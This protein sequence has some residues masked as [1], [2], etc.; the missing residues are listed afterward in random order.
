MSHFN[1]DKRHFIWNSLGTI[2][3]S[4]VSIM[5]LLFTARWLSGKETDIFSIA[6]ALAQQFY[7]LGYFYVRNYQATDVD[8][9]YTFVDYWK[10][11]LVTVFLMLATAAIYIWFSG[12]DTYKGSIIFLMV[13]YRACD[14]FS[15]VYQG[16]FQQKNQ[17]GLAGKI[18]FY[19][20]WISILLFALSLY[21]FKD[22][23]LTTSLVFICNFLLF[24]LLDYRFLQRYAKEHKQSWT[25]SLGGNR[26]IFHIIKECFPLFINGFLIT[27]IY[28]EPKL[29]IDKL[30]SKGVLETGVQR[31]F[32][33]LFM[34]VFVLS[35]LFFILRPITTQ[36]SFYWLKRQYI[37]FFKQVKVLF[38]LMA[39]AGVGIAL[40]GYWIGPEVLGLVYGVSLTPYR[41]VLLLLLIGGILNV[42]GMIV[43]ILLTIFR[44][45]H[46]L[47]M[48]YVVTFLA[49]QQS[50]TYLTE[51]YGMIG[52]A[53]AFLLSMSVFLLT[54]LLA[55]WLVRKNLVLIEEKDE[56]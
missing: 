28:N 2:S 23:L 36:L 51:T 7:A 1:T 3:A 18:Q 10:T 21:L 26:A 29:V 30:L 42:L 43:D 16:Y 55:Y 31:D 20:S 13:L 8:E 6:F 5:L 47:L 45:Q 46:Y 11:R 38:L 27:Y 52:T 19:R 9:K 37:L 41:E 56:T 40:V 4:V 48:V 24:F 32:S 35:L 17:S 12:Y 49:A 34:P 25:W 50:T 15:D 44:K 53:S 22:L 14:A 33:I 39:L 54:S